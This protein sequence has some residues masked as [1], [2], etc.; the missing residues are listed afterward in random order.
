[1]SFLHCEYNQNEEKQIGNYIL[2]KEIGSGGF[3][4]VY[5]SLH[6]PTGEKVAIKVLNKLLFQEGS[7]NAK[8]L[9]REISILKIV[10]H[11]NIIKLYE[12]METPQKIYLQGGFYD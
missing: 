5:L 7:L 9:Q 2:I 3:A 10:K 12:V 11:K 8:R 1:M 6:I 4:K